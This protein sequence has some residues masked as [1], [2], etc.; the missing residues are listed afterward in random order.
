MQ[1]DKR[2]TVEINTGTYIEPCEFE[3]VFSK[4]ESSILDLHVQ[5][6]KNGLSVCREQPAEFNKVFYL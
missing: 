3:V 6:Y 2:G 1:N 5:Q 4:Q